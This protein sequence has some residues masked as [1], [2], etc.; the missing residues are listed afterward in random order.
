M[1][2]TVKQLLCELQNNVGANS[3]KVVDVVPLNQFVL[4]EYV[5]FYYNQALTKQKTLKIKIRNDDTSLKDQVFA[6]EGDAIN[7]AIHAQINGLNAELFIQNFEAF[8]LNF[9]AVRLIL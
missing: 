2:E 1:A 3:T 5:V 4:L 8:N 9:K 7:V 6:K